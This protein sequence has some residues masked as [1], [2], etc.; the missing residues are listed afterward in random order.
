M[1]RIKVCNRFTVINDLGDTPI[2]RGEVT[3]YTAIMADDSGL[4]HQ[5]NNYAHD[6][7]GRTRV[8]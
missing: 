8:W 1:I 5:I 2:A 4:V 3:T 6:A 7:F